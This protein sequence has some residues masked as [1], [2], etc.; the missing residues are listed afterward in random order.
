MKIIKTH[1]GFTLIE[2]LVSMLLTG[3]MVTSVFE[4]YVSMHNQTMV[5]DEISELQQNSRAC[6]I[7]ITKTLRMAGFKIGTHAPYLIN[8]DSLYVFYNDTQLVDTILYYLSPHPDYDLQGE[9]ADEMQGSEGAGKPNQLMKKVNSN[10]ATVFSDYV[11]DINFTQV[12]PSTI[13]VSITTQASKPDEDYSENHGF[14]TYQADEHV[15]LR[16]I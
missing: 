15:F 10:R 16:N 3:I 5:Q 9:Y 14:R 8:G 2:M 6:I 1:S 4:F 11:L 7:D 12:N 13:E